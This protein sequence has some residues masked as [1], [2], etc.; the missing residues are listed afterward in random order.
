VVIDGS[1][2]TGR[3]GGTW[4]ESSTNFGTPICDVATCGTGGGTGPRS[5]T[6]WVWLGGFDGVE[7][8]LVN[9]DVTIPVGVAELSFW[10]QIPSA[11]QSGNDIFQVTLDSVV[12]FATD[13]TDPT[14]GVAAYALQTI[15]VSAFADG[16]THTLEF[17]GSVQGDGPPLTSIT[18][19]FVDDVSLT[20]DLLATTPTAT[21]TPEPGLLL[22]LASGVLGLLVLD[23]RRR[24]ANG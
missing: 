23:K 15:D 7:T 10:L 17:F 12:V 14:A 3:S 8:A 9:Q 22:Q 11:A 18:S 13:R 24:S 2:E 1:F 20:V 16:G 21:P 19:F 4:F 6:F 5:G